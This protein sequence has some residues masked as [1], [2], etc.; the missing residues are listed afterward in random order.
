ML[1]PYLN[2]TTFAQNVN[3]RSKFLYSA[4]LKGYKVMKGD[5]APSTEFEII[6]W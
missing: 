4:I 2:T 3:S 6:L 5:F 1:I